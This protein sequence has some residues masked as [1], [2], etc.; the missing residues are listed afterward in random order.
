MT[1]TK[2]KEVIQTPPVE[3]TDVAL[4]TSDQSPEALIAR[5][6][7]RGL[8]VETMERIL[9]MGREVRAEKAKAEYDHAMSDFQSECPTIQKTQIVKNKDGSTRYK[10]A[11][12]EKIVEQVKPT[13]QK[14]G[15]SYTID[16]DV[17]DSWVTAICKITHEAGHSEK[18]KFKVPIDKDGFMSAPQ[19]FAAALT[20]AKRYAF[21]NSF[22]I[23]TGD[24]DNDAPLTDIDQNLFEE[25]REMIK[26]AKNI[27]GLEYSR[28]GI[29]KSPK[30]TDQ[31]KSAL[32][33][34]IEVRLEELEK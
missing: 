25:A 6:I 14:H 30:Y 21:C 4:A 23:L 27:K 31:Q 1:K 8:P 20:F 17:E 22:G 10:F 2:E 18:S 9:A 3:P 11:P 34:L 12:I 26:K 13:I 28:D 24:E 7:D 5:A 33:D 29:L 32:V 15:F 16:A 19:K